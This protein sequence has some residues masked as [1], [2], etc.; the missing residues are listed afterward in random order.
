[1][2]RRYAGP[3]FFVLSLVSLVALV[4]C[5]RAKTGAADADTDAQAS[6]VVPPPPPAAEATNEADVARFPGEL[7]IDHVK[8]TLWWTQTKVR[9]VPPS[10]EVLATLPKGV[11]VTQ[12]ASSDK[13]ILVT[14]DN[15]NNPTT[16]LMGWVLKDVFAAPLPPAPLKCVAPQTLLMADVNFCAKICKAESDCVA[17]QTCQGAAQLVLPNG[18][19]G[20][21]VRNCTAPAVARDAGAPR[22]DAGALI[23]PVFVDAGVP[24]VADAAVAPAPVVPVIVPGVIIAPTGL[25]ACAPDFLFVPSDNLCHHRCGPGAASAVCKDRRCDKAGF[26]K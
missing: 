18:K 22:T 24:V 12:I 13:Y 15:P 14:F 10:G 25:N 2:H 6:V 8:A 16:H 9:K 23:L 1:M 20:E 5:P 7:P 4:G 17:P 19:P 21:S 3:G 11:V 26:C